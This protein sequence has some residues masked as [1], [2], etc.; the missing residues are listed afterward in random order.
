MLLCH[1]FIWERSKGSPTLL[2]NF[3]F[4]RFFFTLPSFSMSLKWLRFSL[5]FSHLNLFICLCPL[6]GERR[7]AGYLQPLSL[8]FMREDLHMVIRGHPRTREA[9][10]QMG[11]NC[12]PAACSGKVT[13]KWRKQEIVSLYHWDLKLRCAFGRNFQSTFFLPGLLNIGKLWAAP[14]IDTSLSFYPLDLHLKAI[15]GCKVTF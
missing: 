15:D 8:C 6:T 4:L 14:L 12:L 10:I 1:Q 3:L 11:Q 9:C 13:E 2:D 5:L 7:T